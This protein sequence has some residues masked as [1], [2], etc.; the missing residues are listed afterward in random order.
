MNRNRIIFYIAFGTFH[1]GAFIFTV[2]LNN[3]TGLLFKM[4]SYVPMFKWVTFAGLLMLLADAGWSFIAN[5]NASK[6]NA[7]LTQE[8]N[9]LKAKLFDLQEAAKKQA[10]IVAQKEAEK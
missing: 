5:R 10:A 7:A 2:M 1:L 3:D 4:V 6:E 9:M 8:L